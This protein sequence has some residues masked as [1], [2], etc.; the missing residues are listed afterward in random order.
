MK[1]TRA[2]AIDG[3]VASGKTTVGR[4]VADRMNC[5]FLDTGM[6]YRAATL[7]AIRKNIS[8]DDTLS[9][10]SVASEMSMSLRR[11]E[12]HDRLFIDNEDVTDS[13]RDE[14]VEQGVSLVSAVPKVRRAMVEQ[15]RNIASEGPIV[16][17]GRDIG[18]VVLPYA[19]LKVFLTASAEMRAQR[20]YLELPKDNKTVQYEQVLE[21]LIRRDRID[22]ERDDSPLAASKDAVIID[23]SGMTLQDVIDEI[24]LLAGS[25]V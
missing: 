22:S 6:M 7:A 4:L 2:I 10:G 18:T 23:T 5:R 15:Q 11:I 20:R 1:I 17:V 12:G 24:V 14:D 25:F 8:F 13:L 9:M 16:M 19:R 21:D 3:P